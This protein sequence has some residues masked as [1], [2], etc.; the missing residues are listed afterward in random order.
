MKNKLLITYLLIETLS[1]NSLF[2]DE[3]STQVNATSSSENLSSSVPVQSNEEPGI[4]TCVNSFDKF[5]EQYTSL[6]KYIH[7]SAFNYNYN[8]EFCEANIS[9]GVITEDSVSRKVFTFRWSSASPFNFATAIDITHEKNS[10]SLSQ[11]L[12]DYDTYKNN[13]KNLNS[14]HPDRGYALITNKNDVQLVNDKCTVYV[15][16]NSIHGLDFSNKITVTW[17][18]GIPPNVYPSNSLFR[19][20]N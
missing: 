15:A 11:C 1:V 3:T 9:I 16:K 17:H 13:L 5:T 20:F 14:A 4:T 7:F 18:P 8:G 19:T 6:E 2:A 10:T 12:D